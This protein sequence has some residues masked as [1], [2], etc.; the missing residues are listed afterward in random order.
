MTTIPFCAS[1]VLNV[2]ILYLYFSNSVLIVLYVCSDGVL[3]P[4]CTVHYNQQFSRQ[5]SCCSANAMKCVELLSPKD[6][7]YHVSIHEN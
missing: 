4:G 7:L 1:T 2:I 6:L 3:F 5:D